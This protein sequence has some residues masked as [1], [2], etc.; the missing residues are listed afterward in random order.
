MRPLRAA[1]FLLAPALA[2]P[3]WAQ[4]IATIAGNGQP[5]AGP[6]G[7]PA[8]TSPLKLNDSVPGNVLADRDGNL[9]FPESAA[10][11]VRRIERKTGTIATVAGSGEAGFS[12]DGGPATAA[13]L[14]EP[15]DLAFDPDGNLVIADAGNNRVR[16]VDRTNG[17]IET[18]L[19]TGR[20]AFNKDGLAGKETSVGRPTGI[21][22]DARGNLYVADSFAGRIL[23]LDA[24]TGLVRTVA[25]NNSYS[26][27]ANAT[28]ATATGL[29]VPSQVRLTSTGDIVVSVT[30]R[31][32]LMKVNPD[33]GAMTRLAG[34]GL[35]G[36]TGDGGPARDARVSQP[37]AL[38]L[39]RGDNVW[40][41]DWDN[42]AVRRVDAKSGVIETRV[43][44]SRVDRFHQKQ[45]AGF[46]GDGG[47]AAKALLW[48]PSAL[49]FDK[50]GSLYILDARNGRLRKVEKAAR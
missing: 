15:S 19:G 41:A 24:K 23:R 44:S 25:G 13:R 2:A 1:A 33:T 26:F 3:L 7:V 22:F 45:T 10:H 47:P 30:G 6:D 5:E 31:H 17:V 36:Y 8:A 14:R 50:D 42:N 46:S 38:A 48:H 4:T 11:R 37:A 27:D 34:T 29:P 16:R 21:A 32:A 28:S 43:G 40:F 9:H 18:I 35:P 20:P 12:G 49:G 39:D